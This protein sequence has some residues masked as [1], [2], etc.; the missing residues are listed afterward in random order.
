MKA[1]FMNSFNI[2][3][4][5]IY[6]VILWMNFGRFLFFTIAVQPELFHIF[7]RD[8]ETSGTANADSRSGP[9]P[10]SKDCLIVSDS[11]YSGHGQIIY[12]GFSFV[13]KETFTQHVRAMLKFKVSQLIYMV[14]CIRLND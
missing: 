13:S 9:S 6:A 3:A 8:V 2:K 1:S 7:T 10:R 4:A 12:L 11:F 5:L 14:A